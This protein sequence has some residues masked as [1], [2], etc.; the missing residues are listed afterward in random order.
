MQP[1]TSI[2]SGVKGLRVHIRFRLGRGLS[3]NSS[4]NGSW[5][6]PVQ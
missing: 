4:K 5:N 6:M 3:N 2:C 1:T